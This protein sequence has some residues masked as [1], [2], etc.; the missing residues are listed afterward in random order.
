MLIPIS[1]AP[2]SVSRSIS[3]G[4][5]NMESPSLPEIT[6]ADMTVGIPM[7]TTGT[8]KVEK[9]ISY[10]WF[11]TPE[12]GVIPA[13]ESW[14]VVPRRFALEAASASTAI[15]QEGL[16]TSQMPFIISALS[17]PVSPRTPVQTQDTVFSCS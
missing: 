9:E 10:L 12:P 3:L 15:T 6:E 16:T 8:P 4:V 13:V 11:P 17:I 2:C 14:T 7:D 1:F 5:T